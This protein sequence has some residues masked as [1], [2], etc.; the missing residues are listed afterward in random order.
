M[1]L[2][3]Q[4]VEYLA[5]FISEQGVTMDHSKVESVLEWPTARNVKSVMGFLGLMGYYRKFIERY[6]KIAKPLTN[7]TRKD[8]FQW[9]PKVAGAF[10]NLKIALTS[11]PVLALPNFFQPFQIECDASG[12]GLGAVLMQEGRRIA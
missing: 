7:L 3:R 2:G 11:A 4:Q 1:G 9:G 6:G 12:R 5:H 8:G 10:E